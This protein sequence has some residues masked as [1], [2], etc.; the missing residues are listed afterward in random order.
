[1]PKR[2]AIEALGDLLAAGAGQQPG[3]LDI[4]AV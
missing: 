4:D 1:M 3:A 2:P